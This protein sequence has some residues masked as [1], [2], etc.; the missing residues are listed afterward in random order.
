MWFLGRWMDTTWSVSLIVN[1]GSKVVI[2]KVKCGLFPFSRIRFFFYAF[3]KAEQWT[4]G[5]GH[6]KMKCLTSG[7]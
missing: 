3:F 7:E 2:G 1:D 6:N 5:G 4:L